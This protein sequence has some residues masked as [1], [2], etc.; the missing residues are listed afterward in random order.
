[1]K[2]GR[3]VK[4]LTAKR[5][6]FISQES[7]FKVLSPRDLTKDGFF[8]RVKTEIEMGF[9]VIVPGIRDQLPRE[10]RLSLIHI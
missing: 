10:L 2:A 1:M 9:S 6:G 7:Q 3:I 5:C 4:F 8:D